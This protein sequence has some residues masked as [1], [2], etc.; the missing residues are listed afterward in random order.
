MFLHFAIAAASLSTCAPQAARPPATPV[1][2]IGGILEA[3]KS[4]QIVALTDAHGNEQAHRFLLSLIRDPRFAG[5]VND[6][7]VE[8]GSA[9]YQDVIDRFVRGEDVPYETLRKV[10]QDTTQPSAAAD[11]PTHEEFFRAVRAVNGS[12]PRERQVRVLLGDPPI[13][14]DKIRGRED[15][16]KWIEMR[17]AYPAALIQLE[18][19]AKQRRAL[20][21]YG[22]GHFQRRNVLANFEMADWRAQTIV[23][24][25]ER[26][27]PVKIFTVWSSRDL[28]DLQ[29][30]VATWRVPSLAII[31]GTALGAV[32]AAK[33]FGWGG[34]FAVRDGKMVQVPKE[35]WRTLPAE[36]QFDAVLY[37]GPPSAMT[38]SRWSPALCADAAYMEMRLKRI[39]TAG[40]PQAEADRLKKYCAD[41]AAKKE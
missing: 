24:L 15:H 18:V 22:L 6:I 34:R 2:G 19:I 40:I 8:F 25:L 41:V 17:D 26:S 11:L 38:E 30:D 1:E 16:F 35:E 32:D 37:L 28:A 29:P 20:L 39:A 3:Y 31:R 36:D 13:D 4:N 5:I 14:W 23:S 10:W 21:V 9:R 27:G 33:Y 7:V 12:L